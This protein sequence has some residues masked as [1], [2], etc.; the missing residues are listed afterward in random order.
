MERELANRTEQ[1]SLFR[2]SSR[3]LRPYLVALVGATHYLEDTTQEER[4]IK[5]HCI[6]FGVV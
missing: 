6:E 4:V 3:L 5:G 1:N 2:Q